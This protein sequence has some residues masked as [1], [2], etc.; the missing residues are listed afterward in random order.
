MTDMTP[1]ERSVYAFFASRCIN[2]VTGKRRNVFKARYRAARR[3]WFGNIKHK[4]ALMGLGRRLVADGIITEA[5]WG[6]CFRR[7]YGLSPTAYSIMSGF[8]VF[9]A[10]RWG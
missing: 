10:Y 8:A 2:E 5:E 9:A 1:T 4:T 7:L 6:D 3:R